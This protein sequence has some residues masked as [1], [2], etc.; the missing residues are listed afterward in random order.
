[1]AHEDRDGEVPRPRRQGG[2]CPRVDR[3]PAGEPR[4]VPR[5]PGA[6]ADVRGD[7]LLRDRRGRPVP[8][9]V[10]PPGRG[11]RRAQ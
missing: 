7:D 6:R 3:V 10:H 2:A 8:V 9:V 5:D 11:R 1:M 4:G